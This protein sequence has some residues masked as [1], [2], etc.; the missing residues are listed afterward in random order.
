ME[1]DGNIWIA[2]KNCNEKIINRITA[3]NESLRTQFVKVHGF[4][5][6][7]ISGLSLDEYNECFDVSDQE[8]YE[9]SLI[10]VRDV[11]LNSITIESDSLFKY[12]YIKTRYDKPDVLWIAIH[13]LLVD[14]F[15]IEIL[16][17]DI[18]EKY[19]HFIAYGMFLI[20]VQQPVW[21]K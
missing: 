2:R 18:L 5:G 8:N 3:E 21:K 6:A 9:G 19:T 13:H 10:Q 17:S 4:H 12:S 11:I 14:I 7:K 16:L 15:S 20:F 1:Y